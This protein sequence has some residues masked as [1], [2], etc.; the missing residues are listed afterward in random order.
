MESLAKYGQQTP[1]V[2]GRGGVVLK[3]NATLEA[4]TR[5]GW[6]ELAAIPFDRQTEL[7][8]GYKLVDNRSAELATWAAE[9]LK[10]E[11]RKLEGEDLAKLGWNADELRSLEDNELKQLE[12]DA[13]MLDRLEVT[14]AEPKTKCQTGQVIKLGDAT[15]VIADPVTEVAK[16]LP[17]LTP[18]MIFAPY[19]GPYAALTTNGAFNK[20]LLVQPDPFIAG[21]IVDHYKSIHP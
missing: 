14:I 17:Y 18:K 4:A 3:G 20:I 2:V 13:S 7:V 1:L 12:S 16:W 19:P 9:V 5:L 10:D 15:L 8:R 21:H 6:G 11:L